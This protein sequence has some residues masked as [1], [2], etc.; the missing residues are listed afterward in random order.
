MN[1]QLHIL[2][3]EDDEADAELMM[4]E[5]HRA[6]IEFISRRVD[7]KE[8]FQRELTDFTPDLVLADYTLP[9]FDG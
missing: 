8:D 2:I 6:N 4:R 5:L 7:T 3:L 1:K 9:S